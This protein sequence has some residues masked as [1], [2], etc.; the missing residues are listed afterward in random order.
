MA[1]SKVCCNHMDLSCDLVFQA[2]RLGVKKN[3]QTLSYASKEFIPALNLNQPNL[4]FPCCRSFFRPNFC[5]T[6]AKVAVDLEARPGTEDLR[7]T[8]KV[9]HKNVDVLCL[10]YFLLKGIFHSHVPCSFIRV[11]IASILTSPSIIMWPSLSSVVIGGSS[12]F[13]N[14]HFASGTFTLKPSHSV[15]DSVALS[16][17]VCDLCLALAK[18]SNS[19]KNLPR[20]Q[21][22]VW[23]EV[24][25]EKRAVK[26]KLEQPQ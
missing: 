26:C 13:R 10:L 18:S 14:F 15:Q 16:C 23:L 22:G 25:Y 3:G 1:L 19:E 2:D 4:G 24:C 20:L 9:Y 6:V 8:E 17:N 12:S 21:K 7:L 11:V 5:A